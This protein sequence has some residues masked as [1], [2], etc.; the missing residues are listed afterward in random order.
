MWVWDQSKGELTHNGRFVGRGYSGANIG[1]NNPDLEAKVAT[2]PIPRGH[3]VISGPPYTSPNI[4]PFALHLNPVGHNAKGR[5]LFKIHGD[6][7]KAPGKASK[8]CIILP[9]NIREMIWNSG[10]RALEVVE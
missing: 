6:S 10:D 4:G 7:A 2:G 1:K 8:G 3:W 5:S 9:R